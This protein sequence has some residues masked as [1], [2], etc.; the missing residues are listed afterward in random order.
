MHARPLTLRRLLKETNSGQSKRVRLLDWF[1]SQLH[2]R[3]TNSIGNNQRVF[4]SVVIIIRAHIDVENGSPNY[5][6]GF[7]DFFKNSVPSC[8]RTSLESMAMGSSFQVRFRFTTNF[9]FF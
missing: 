8:P 2:E 3:D 7:G 9:Y 5:F 1:G 4:P 6:I